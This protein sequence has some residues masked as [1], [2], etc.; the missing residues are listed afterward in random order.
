M[1]PT[2]KQCTLLP[3]QIR[4]EDGR[5]ICPR[6]TELRNGKCVKD[7]PPVDSASCC[8]ARS[9]SRTAAASA[10]AAPASSGAS[11]ARTQPPQCKL[12]AGPDQARERPLRLPAWHEPRQGR[13]PQGRSRRSA[14]CC[15]ARSGSRTAAAS[16]R[17]EQASSG[18]SAARTSRR[19]ASCFPARSGSRTAAASA[20]VEQASSGASAAR[21]SRRS[22]SCCR[23]RSAWRTAVASARV[24][25]ASSGASAARRRRTAAR[26]VRSARR[27]TAG[28]WSS[29]RSARTCKSC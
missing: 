8:R 25:P 29:G 23:A 10:R 13:V 16:A 3:G 17:A 12:L 18:A 5:C 24:A 22:A 20:R 15:P 6:G 19:S 27:R 9:G 14:S 26:A 21:I 4:T 7:E 1:P 2:V 28:S 11:A